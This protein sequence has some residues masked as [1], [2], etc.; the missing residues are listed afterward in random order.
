MMKCHWVTDSMVEVPMQNRRKEADT[1]WHHSLARK[2]QERLKRV[3]VYSL[4]NVESDIET[5]WSKNYG[6][7]LIFSKLWHDLGLG[8]VIA[9]AASDAK[10]DFDIAD[11]AYNMTLNRLHSPRSK[12]QLERWQE[13]IYGINHYDTHQY[14][15]AMDRLA[16]CQD[17]IEKSLFTRMRLLHE[18]SV[19]IVLFDTTTLV[20]YGEGEDGEKLL[21]RGFS[22]AKRGDLKQV[23]IGVVMSQDGIPLAHEVF[24]GNKN[25]VMCFK[26]IIDKISKKFSIKK[27]VLVGDRGMINNP[28][29][30]H[31]SDKGFEYILGFRMRTI[32]AEERAAVL[33]KANFK[34][35]KK[36]SLHWREVD[37]HGQ[38]L[39]V[40]YNPERAELDKKKREDILERL[41]QKI[42]GASIKTIVTNPEYKKFLKISGD[43]PKIDQD[44][45]A[46]DALYDG[47]FVLTTNTKMGGKLIVERYKDLWQIEAGF[48]CLKDELQ[49][50]PIYHWKD[51]RI[52]AHILIC[53]FALVMRIIARKKLKDHDSK[54]SY[55]DVMNDLDDLAAT[56]LSLKGDRIITTTT[57]KPGAAAAITALKI[58]PPSKILDSKITQP[59][60]M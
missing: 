58:N 6:Y 36:E 44:K 48:R 1:N 7:P 10:T 40:C 5:E 47:I 55:T 11:V 45:V 28:N 9:N 54:L 41:S 32:P 43:N 46:K 50:G 14:Y 60:L 33:A 56:A 37:Y 35:I 19:D 52:K 49:A 8:D 39:I 27:V 26:E 31:L 51:R 13:S 24:S 2:C 21:A 59:H 34:V 15:R 57:V 38:R 17:A 29:L 25:D 30:K 22:K 3:K 18:Q 42:K 16:E 20:Y 4:L 12:R 23:V 53:F